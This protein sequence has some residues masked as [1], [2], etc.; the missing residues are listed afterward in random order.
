MSESMKGLRHMP[1][2]RAYDRKCWT[3]R[4]SDGLGTEKQK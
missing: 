3:D 1:M 4:H 2:R